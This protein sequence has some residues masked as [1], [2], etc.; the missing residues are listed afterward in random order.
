MKRIFILIGIILMTA[1]CTLAPRYTKPEA[2]VPE[3]WPE[4]GAYREA[5]ER[6][7]APSVPDLAWREFITDGKLRQVIEMA[8][9]NNRDLKLAALNVEKVRALYGIQRSELFPTVDAVGSGSKQRVPGDLTDSGSAKTVEQYSVNLGVFSWEID[10]FGRLR[11]LKD[12][13]LEEYLATE[14]ARRGTEIL[15]VSEVAAAYFA[16]A[17]ERENLELAKS[18]LEARKASYGL[19]KRQQECGLASELDLRRAQTTVDT[20]RVDVAR[21]IQSAAQSENALIFLAGSPVPEDL[22]PADLGG[23]SPPGEISPGLSSDVLLGRPDILAAEHRLKASNA[24]IGAAR[25]AFFPRISLTA[26]VGT[27]SAELSGLFGS[28]SGTWL[29]QPNVV[30]PIFDARIWSAYDAARA[31]EKIILAR[32]EKAIQNAFR[33][34]ADGLAVQ[35]TM[36][37]QLSAQRSLVHASAET[38]RLSDIRYRKGIDSFLGVLDAQRTF[39]GARQGLVAVRLRQL[40]NQVRLYGALGGGSH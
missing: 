39:Y 20:A 24:N 9:V 38:Y 8:L 17:A 40:V 31:E 37:E 3:V 22:L 25:A 19:I 30:L 4:G 7:A 35:G 1:G 6:I 32:Y 18:T 29:F 33:E 15:L 21:L 12:Q 2:P 28:G 26:A 23:V 36:E 13:A 11:S 16:L 5:G 27:A 10:L 34:V 14:E